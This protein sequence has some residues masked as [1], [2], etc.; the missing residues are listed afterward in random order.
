MAVARPKTL[1]EARATYTVNSELAWWVFMR[2]SGLALIFL[3][4]GHLYMTNILINAGEID[5]NLVSERLSITWVKVYD[6]FLLGLAMLHGAN[7]FRYSVEDY[8]ANPAPRF[9]VKILLYSLTVVIFVFG[10]I[11]LW[12][13]DYTQFGSAAGGH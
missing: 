9:F 10:I 7:G 2:V 11:S 8:I 3:T 12:A 6:T 1:R 4:F 13:I 5:F